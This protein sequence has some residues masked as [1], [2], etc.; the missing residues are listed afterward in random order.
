MT[1][2][3]HHET[4]DSATTQPLLLPLPPTAHTDEAGPIEA[5][6]GPGRVGP[7]ETVGGELVP[8]SGSA[9]PGLDRARVRSAIGRVIPNPPAV[10][11]A[12]M[13]DRAQRAGRHVGHV[14]RG[15]ALLVGRWRDARGTTRYERQLR[16]AE[17]AGDHE[18]L[19][20]WTERHERAKR[21][22]HERREARA[23]DPLRPVKHVAGWAAAAA[24]VL[25]LAGVLLAVANNDLA[26]F[27]DPFDGLLWLVRSVSTLV[28]ALALP[29][30]LAAPPVALLVAWWLGRSADPN[31][32][33]TW[34]AAERM[35]TSV[36]EVVPDENAILAALRN[37][38]LPVLNRKIKEGWQPRFVQPTTRDGQGY[39]TQ[40]ELPPGVTVEMVND[41]KAVLAHNLVRQPVE[42]WPTEPKRNP[43]VLDLW[44]A[45]QGVLTGPT[46]AY[47]LLSEGGTDYFKGVPVGVNQR[48]QPVTGKLM[49]CN[50]GIAGIMGSGKTSLVISLLAGAVLDP[51]VHAEVY[52]LASN[53]DY[54][55]FTPRLARLVTGDEDEQITQVM[56]TLRELRGEVTDRGRL[57]REQGG[58]DLKLT[59]AVA[60]AD[61]RMR[62]KVIII[63]E[64]QELFRHE[65]HGDEAKELA[66]KLMMK[67]RKVGITLIFVTPAPSA[68]N[69]PR[70]LAKTTS[71]RVCFAIGDHQANDAILGTGAHKQGITATNLTPG[72]DI[73]TAMASGFAT[74]PGLL[75]SYH[76][77]KEQGTD[78]ITPIVN[79]ALAAQQ[80]TG[81]DDQPAP[82]VEPADGDEVDPLADI[83]A[84]L[85]QQVG[86]TGRLRT[87]EVL[88]ALAARNRATYA[89]WTFTDL[90]AALPD[91]AKPY[92]TDGTRKLAAERVLA[93]LTGRNQ[94][95]GEASGAGEAEP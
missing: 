83:A 16:A 58:E 25:V 15:G 30:L 2:E 5:G 80:E 78:E 38:N 90:A 49:G 34:V 93:A 82:A 59:R 40:L 6:P 73:G 95:D 47:P 13:L 92:K 70:D 42:V 87:Q 27:F 39:S 8:A 50:Y 1:I 75:R 21:E 86:Y 84:V 61:P 68:S 11:R 18:R 77:R 71:H 17:A 46:P 64:C 4:D 72:E 36:R 91:G 9:A 35:D 10:D 37:L 14:R 54:D 19:A 89:S 41:R 29:V 43:G 7:A 26:A 85:Y 51:L 81:I 63:D 33:A 74:R 52:V 60:E 23:A 94:P 28:A 44:V 57:L 24:L 20:E 45:D 32:G 66:I 3:D 31:P 62:P 56:Q 22:R 55:A 65:S 12:R 76:L 79:R 48:G 69:L 53:A 88:S 67:A